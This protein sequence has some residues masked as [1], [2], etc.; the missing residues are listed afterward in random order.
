MLARPVVSLPSTP[1]AQRPAGR[2]PEM[3]F[4]L[5]PHVLE[6][7]EDEGGVGGSSLAV[8][9]GT[10]ILHSRAAYITKATL[11]PS[12]LPAHEVLEPVSARPSQ[13]CRARR[14]LGNAT[15]ASEGT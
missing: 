6:K 3:I 4:S 10:A 13:P 8:S 5:L 12:R 14:V 9:P 2:T 7:E 1:A 11:W 15:G